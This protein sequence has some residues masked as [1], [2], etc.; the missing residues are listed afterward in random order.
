MHLIYPLSVIAKALIFLEIL[1]GGTMVDPRW[2]P[3]SN[4]D[5]IPSSVLVINHE[6]NIVGCTTVEPV[7]SGHPRGMAK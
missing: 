5:Y 4:H 3:F 2:S 1:V 7:L 6:E